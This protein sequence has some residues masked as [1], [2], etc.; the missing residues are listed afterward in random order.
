MNGVHWKRLTRTKGL[1]LLRVLLPFLL[2]CFAIGAPIAFA[3]S[4]TPPSEIGRGFLDVKTGWAPAAVRP[5]AEDDPFDSVVAVG[6]TT[7]WKCSGV[8]VRSD[9]VLTARHCLPAQQVLFGAALDAP[10]RFVVSVTRVETPPDRTV[11]VALLFLSSPVPYPVFVR[12]SSHDTEPPLGQLR[13]VGF[14]ATDR[15]A[16]SVVG[17]KSMVDFVVSGWGCSMARAHS[18]GCDPRFEMAITAATGKDTCRGDSG[19]PVFEYFDNSWRLVA[20][21][22]RSLRSARQVCGQGGVYTR[23]DVLETWLTSF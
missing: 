11:D 5:A 7:S 1:I 6:T 16:D 18:L 21:V 23:V 2:V 3:Q 4:T 15:S 17:R 22:S 13:A 14:G 9:V 10:D 20:I 19:G 8:L 12:R